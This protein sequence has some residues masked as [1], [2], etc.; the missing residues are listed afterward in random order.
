MNVAPTPIYVY[1]RTLS[2]GTSGSGVDIIESEE[3]LCMNG[4][5]YWY[6]SC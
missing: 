5:L 1:K 4:P 3:V 2:F 6:R